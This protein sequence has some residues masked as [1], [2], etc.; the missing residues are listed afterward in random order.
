VLP[1]AV[2]IASAAGE[3]ITFLIEAAMAARGAAVLALSGGHTPEPI[4]QL[5]ADSTHPWRA[6]IDWPRVHVYWSDERNVPPDHPDSNFGLA[7]RA[8]IQHVP[9][10][11]S[12]V[13]RMRGE[14]PAGEAGNEYDTILRA[15]RHEAPGPL[16]DVLLLGIGPDAHIA[17]IF[18]ESP[19]LAV[20]RGFMLRQ[21]G[22][23][24]S[25]YAD[26]SSADTP[27]SSS[28]DLS[29]PQELAT[30][31][32]APKLN[33]WRITL[34]PPALLDSTAIIVLA[35]G[36]GKADA[37]AAAL[38]GD[39]DIARHPA[40]ILRDAGDRADWI[41]DAAAAARLRGARRA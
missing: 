10:P 2:A 22:P 12:Q 21:A 20:G 32:W 19:L 11:P 41:I 27:G 40:Q 38:E 9:I 37:I 3:R 6:R 14:L 39:L 8:L 36:S 13:H 16:F 15:R 28:A 31:V 35:A 34:T 17:S 23:K 30:G 29:G 7:N 26:A 18:P 25:P 4:Y 24:G 33:Q 5:L 1:D